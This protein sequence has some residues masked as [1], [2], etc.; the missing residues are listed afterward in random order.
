MSRCLV[1]EIEND[2]QL[3]FKNVIYLP[4]WTDIP[5][6]SNL[7]KKN[8]K[9]YKFIFA[10]RIATHKGFNIVV[11]AIKNL[12]LNGI[13]NFTVDFYGD[14]DI[15]GL[16]NYINQQG[17]TAYAKYCGNLSK[18]SLLVKYSEYDALLFPTWEREPFGFVIVEA[19]GQGAIPILTSTC[20]ASEWL[21]DDFNCLKVRRHHQYLSEA[22][23]YLMSLSQSELDNFKSQCKT[24]AQKLFD[25]KFVLTQLEDI[26]IAKTL[27][28]QSNHDI[29][30]RTIQAENALSCLN[31]IF[32]S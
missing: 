2:L 14:G 1:K 32:V 29:Q 12:T 5:N 17:I 15:S 31:T 3:K 28:F 4:G 23:V 22:M 27:S 13:N 30:K 20:G 24:S 9:N 10:S 18:A 16:L 21:I 19:M 26:L 8:S 11:D 25:S 7:E 6:L